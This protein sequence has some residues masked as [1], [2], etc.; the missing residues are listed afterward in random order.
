[1]KTFAKIIAAAAFAAAAI[2]FATPSQAGLFSIFQPKPKVVA[3][4]SISQQKLFLNVTDNRGQTSRYVWNVSTGRTGYDTPMG[5]YHPTWLDANHKSAQY[6]D[7][8]MPYA[9]FFVDGVAIHGTEAVSRLGTRAS[10]GCVR[11]DTSNA[12]AFFQLVEAYG[13]WNTTITVTD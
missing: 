6:E 3:T 4:V 13:K 11:L 10:H 9:V 12:Q 1:M 8:P 5:T 2:G 7:A